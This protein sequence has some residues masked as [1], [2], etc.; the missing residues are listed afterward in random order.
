MSHYRVRWESDV[1]ADSPQATAEE[2]F[3]AM[4]DLDTLATVFVVSGPDGSA[5]AVDL[6]GEDARVRVTDLHTGA[7]RPPDR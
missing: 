5:H 6:R 4:Q 3:A 1:E 2:A 7:G